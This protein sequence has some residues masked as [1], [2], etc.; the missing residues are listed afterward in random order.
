MK[1]S[2][3]SIPTAGLI[4]VASL[5]VQQAAGQVALN[6]VPSRALGHP[7]LQLVTAAPNY[8]EGR[9]M[10]SPSG[11]ALDLSASPPI[12]YVAD[13]GNNRVLAWRNALAFENGAAA[14]VVIGQRDRFSTLP[15]GPAVQGSALSTGLFQPTGLA[16][17]AQGNLYVAD[18]GNNRIL[19]YPRPLA[20]TDDLKFPDMVIGQ[21]N[22]NGGAPNQ[23]TPATP[24]PQTVALNLGGGQVFRSSLL[25]DPAGNL[26]FSDS[27]NNRVLRFPA[28]AL[29]R[30]QNQPAA[31]QAVGQFSFVTRNGNQQRDPRNKAAITA[32][33]G[34]AMDSAGRLYVCDSLNRVLVYPNPATGASAARVLGVVITPEGQAPPPPINDTSLG[35]VS[36]NAALPPE[37][38]FIVGGTPF[39]LD[40]GANRIVR[41]DPFESWPTEGVAFSPRGRQVIGQPD[42]N[43][44]Q[45]NAGRSESNASGFERPVAAVATSN[46]VFI[47]DTGNHRVLVFP[48]QNGTI[49][50][51]T[52]VLGQV[53][54][55]QS[56]PNFV[57]GR[58]T[59]LFNGLQNVG[60]GQSSDGAGIVIDTRS[61]PPRLYVADTYNHRVLGWRDARIVKPGD[62]ADLVIG[63][64]DLRRTLVNDPSGD[65]NQVTQNGLFLPAGLAVDATGN[66]YVADSGNG[67]VLRFPAPFNQP[68][69]LTP[70]LV[71][72]QT[73][74]FN[75][76]TDATPRN[77]SR[78]F[79]LA[80]TVDG[81]LMVSDLSHN[82]I[83]F[84]RR[85]AGG[86]FTNGQAAEKVFGQED[87][88]D[89]AGSNLPNR[90]I[91]PHH[92]SIDT[93]DRLYVADTGNNRILIYD[94][95]TVALLD[96][97]P[98][99]TIPQLSSPHGVFVSPLTGEIWVTN[100]T[101]S[102]LLRYPRF[103]QL[104]FDP[105][106]S[107][108]IQTAANGDFP[109]AVAQDQAGNLFVAESVNRISIFYPGLVPSNGANRLQRY[110]PGAYAAIKPVQGA[111]FGAETLA[112]DPSTSPD[113]MPSTLA[114][115]QVLVNDTP[116]PIQSVSPSEIRF[117]I[118]QGTAVNRRAELTVLRASTGQILAADALVV[119]PV[120]PAFF[121]T[122]GDGNG[123]VVAVN[124]DGKANSPLDP[125]VRASQVSIFG[126]GL[127]LVGG[128]PPDGMKTPDKVP[129]TNE[130][131]VIVGAAFI[132]P[133]DVIYSGLAPGMIGMWQL[134]IKIPNATAPG[135][136]VV[137]A[138]TVNSVPT[139]TD[140]QGGRVRTT[141]A[142]KP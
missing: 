67:R 42:A 54:F 63:Q 26:W 86:D 46:E 91:A 135:P 34:L 124:E 15:Q 3:F 33:A 24:S 104:V 94:R 136:E 90:M 37:A 36:N 66:L 20:Q 92:I 80:F 84:F 96:P 137:V 141:I 5:A 117:I 27:G 73:N 127:G 93:D 129:A 115:I 142:V 98:A 19:R 58:E 9:E 85:P 28:A 87:F 23:S 61:N 88:S 89:V 103:D 56:A 68:A 57:E 39:V 13:T 16:V 116:A 113:P 40:S 1:K 120:A 10:A 62:P 119:T 123:Q 45:A 74:F 64:R 82:R 138:A 122:S 14:D 72:G 21:V 47:A 32:P 79:G 95:V 139:T 25:F 29:T 108:D 65:A 41:Y 77:M 132:E 60:P 111:G 78:P 35:R 69:P 17:D 105:R 71:L 76:I 12:L 130:L 109:L 7:Q 59:Y 53:E 50:T 11:I 128:A 133:A 18:S 44:F 52:R 8:V 112:Y 81:H 4:L 118:P 55:H 107:Y 134:T 6:K 114:D 100:T 97:A 121:T 101:R 99:L 51:A 140:P 22:F 2:M 49:G 102:Q 75:K 125:V 30:G 43:S 110:A 31:D 48:I 70:D 106:P 131:R 38:V 126:T 83:L